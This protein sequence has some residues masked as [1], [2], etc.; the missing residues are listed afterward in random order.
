METVYIETSVIRFPTARPS[1]AWKQRLPNEGWS[2]PRNPFSC[3]VSREVVREADYLP[4]WNCRHLANAVV[5]H[6]IET[7]F[8]RRVFKMPR[9]CTPEALRAW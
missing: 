4:T 6:R 8:R 1:S 2:G 3:F 9:V 7:L 5:L